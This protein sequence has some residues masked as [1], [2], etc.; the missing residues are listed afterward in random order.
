MLV[1]STLMLSALAI[2]WSCTQADRM[3]PFADLET[4]FGTL[5]ADYRRWIDRGM[6]LP[7]ETFFWIKKVDWGSAPEVMYGINGESALTIMNLEQRRDYIP[8]DLVLIGDDGTAA[9]WIAIG[10]SG[11]RAGKVF[12]IDANGAD[13]DK[14]LDQRHVH[15]IAKSFTAWLAGMRENPDE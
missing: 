14:S 15:E 3:N 6:K 13:P 11:A 8:K 1:R 9:T 2:L 10:V 5:P 12:F 4:R 7:D